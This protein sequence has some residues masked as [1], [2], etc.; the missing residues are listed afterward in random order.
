MDFGRLAENWPYKVA[1]I[2]LSVLLWLSVSADEERTDQEV[3]TVLEL[4]VMDSAWSIVDA[5][6]EV[7]TTFQGRGGDILALFNQPRIRKV[8]EVV[9]DSVMN[10]SLSASDVLYNR[11]LAVRATAVTPSEVV[12]RFEHRSGKMVSVRAVSDAHASPG[13]VISGH[14]VNPESVW[15]QGPDSYVRSISELPTDRLEAGAID[16]PVDQQLSVVLPPGLSGVQ[17]TPSSVLVSVRVDS[18]RTRRFQIAIVPTGAHA[19]GTIIDPPSV[20]VDVTGAAALVD[21]LSP[22]DVR[23]T[24]SIE[25]PVTQLRTEALEVELPD[26]VSANTEIFPPRV[27]VSPAIG[28]VSSGRSSS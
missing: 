21:A 24:L 6:S 20:A 13:F 5:P 1:A 16:G 25:Q 8:I 11:S 4:Q 26:G 3:A 19:A 12:V 15:V 28:S 14:E 9:D 2:V 27:T 17:I 7:S 22:S 10:I 18:L 23:V